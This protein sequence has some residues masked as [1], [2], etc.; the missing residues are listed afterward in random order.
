M[1]MKAL[2]DAADRLADGMAPSTKAEVKA[3][4]ADLRPLGPEIEK[5]GEDGLQ[6]VLKAIFGGD[7][8]AARAALILSATPDELI[9]GMAESAEEIENAPDDL[10]AF[11]ESFLSIVTKQIAAVLIAAL[12]VG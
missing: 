11:A 12:K 8:D 2:F 5:I 1:L 9:E 10:S 3:A 6:S 4:I 7:D